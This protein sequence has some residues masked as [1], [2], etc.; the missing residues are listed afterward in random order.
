MTVD[1]DLG[2]EDTSAA[3]AVEMYVDTAGSFYVSRDS[4][5]NV[6][7]ATFDEATGKVSYNSADFASRIH[8]AD[9]HV[10]PR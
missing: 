3:A 6:I 9:H 4:G 7:A 1:A 8:R 5:A 10:Q 2:F